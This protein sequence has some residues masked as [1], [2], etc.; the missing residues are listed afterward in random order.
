M[1]ELVRCGVTR[2][3]IA[4][5]SRSTP[6]VTAVAAH[7]K[8]TAIVHFD[9]R[10]TAFMALG[11]ARAS[12]RAA[13]WI[14][15]SGTA[16]ANGLPAVIEAD[17]ERVP[18]ILLT[19][20]R[21]P[22]LRDTDAN[23][24]IRQPGL[25]GDHIRWM[26]DLPAPD[27]ELDPAYVLTTVDQA[28]GRS[29]SGPVH[30]NCMF[31]EPLA[32]ER[33]PYEPLGEHP[34]FVRW[35]EH[36]RP[37]T[38]Y[39]ASSWDP[40]TVAAGL[41]AAV[42]TAE[43]PLVILGRIGS[44]GLL[45]TSVVDSIRDGGFDLPILADITSQVRLGSGGFPFIPS[46]DA[47]L[48]NK[49]LLDRIGPDLVVQFGRSPVSKRLQQYLE[50]ACPEEWLVVADGDDRI[51]PGHRVTKRISAP[52]GSVFASLVTSMASRS[53]SDGDDSPVRS[54]WTDTWKRLSGAVESWRLDVFE[55]GT[56]LTEQ[57]SAAMLSSRLPA[58]S[59]LCL[60]SSTPVRHMDVFASWTGTRVPVCANRGASGIDGTIATACGY[61]DGSARRGV[62]FLGDLA[63]LH[64]LNSLK[65]AADRDLI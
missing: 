50:T 4:P 46:W 10:G 23:Q 44:A 28:V 52:P 37:Y 30:I 43:R 40:M 48:Y 20:D 29:L 27:T 32:P 65:A 25:F 22:E 6:L 51:D 14:T 45:G 31:R 36:D 41:E 62:V 24:T 17:L 33:V 53:P 60:G 63:L 1:E 18:M 5:G 49:S 2:F 58:R 42:R 64:D 21:P 26:V 39:E 13:A 55:A 57:R 8:A 59:F 61:A 34:A 16:L 3:Y 56:E 19:A 38:S 12:G 9:E 7:D 47:L 35:Q 54:E 15:T 11:Y